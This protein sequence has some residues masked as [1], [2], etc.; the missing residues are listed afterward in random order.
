MSYPRIIEE[1]NNDRKLEVMKKCDSAFTLSVIN[2]AHFD[3]TY[4]RIIKNAVFLVAIDLID[5]N[6]TSVGYAAMY[7]ND[8][9]S[10]TAYISLLCVKKESQGKHIGSMMIS[11]CLEIAKKNS[12]KE[13]K[14]EVLNANEQA[15]SF[16]THLGFEFAGF[17]SEES[18][19]MRRSV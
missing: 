18:S 5:Q 2:S 17:S 6:E 16:Y 3:Q 10:Q 14:L 4:Q 7:A 12:M 9:V 8:K 13:I 11:R 19:F 1:Y 15:I